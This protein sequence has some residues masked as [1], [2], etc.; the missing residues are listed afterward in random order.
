MQR[1]TG[2]ECS[3]LPKRRWIRTAQTLFSAYAAG[4]GAKAATQICHKRTEAESRGEARPLV[5]S[6]LL[7]P[8]CPGRR[9]QQVLRVVSRLH[10]PKYP[11]A[12]GD[13]CVVRVLFV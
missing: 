12:P 7:Q 8:K 13:F 5:A 3:K 1:K 11:E 4:Q 2:T 9:Q 6:R 10:E